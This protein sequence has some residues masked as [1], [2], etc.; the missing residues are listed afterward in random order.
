MFHEG[1]RADGP[2]SAATAPSQGDLRIAGSE[3]EEA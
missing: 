2:Q 1:F 3:I